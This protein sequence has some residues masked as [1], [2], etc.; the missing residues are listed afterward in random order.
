VRLRA[1]MDLG[2]SLME[3][4]EEERSKRL[5]NESGRERPSIY[6]IRHPHPFSVRAARSP[7]R[8]AKPTA[9]GRLRGAKVAL[10]M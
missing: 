1:N 9:E 10:H 4:T 2:D 6:G 5:K 7:G 3:E 8:P